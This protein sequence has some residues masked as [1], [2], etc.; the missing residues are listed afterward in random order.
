MCAILGG[1]LVAVAALV[2]MAT[3][4]PS[5]AED[6]AALANW[7]V[8]G[9]AR[10]RACGSVPDPTCA[11]APR[12]CAGPQA[13]W[14]DRNPG[15]TIVFLSLLIAGAVALGFAYCVALTRTIRR[16]RTSK[17]KQG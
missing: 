7:A 11:R 16:T 8:R 12:A 3:G 4:R 14:I 9:C 5:R 10:A 13:E 1:G 15:A 6:S 2:S 17:P